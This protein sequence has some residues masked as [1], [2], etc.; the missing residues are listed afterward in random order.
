VA[1]ADVLNANS[2]IPMATTRHIV[3]PHCTATNRLPV[4]KPVQAARCGACH[5]ALFQGH[6]AA[7]DGAQ[8]DKH[9]RGNDIALLVDV[10]APWCGPCRAMAPMF[11]RAAA[12]LEPDVR[13][14]KVNADEKPAIASELGVAGIPALL[15]LR[16]GQ[17]IA[18]TAGAM[19]T[20]RI[21]AW[22][23]SHLSGAA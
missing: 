16:G 12:E 20:R 15:L 17:I 4:D 10:W 11:E 13:L 9:R 5:S 8:F 18:R 14:V 6:P 2:V 19:D 21:V 22:T 7:V 3:C 1:P 23:R